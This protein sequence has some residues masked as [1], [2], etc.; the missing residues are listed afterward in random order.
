MLG[1]P[2]LLPLFIRYFNDMKNFWQ[3]WQKITK[4]IVSVQATVLL[5]IVYSI[6]IIPLG[7]FLK[8]FSKDILLGHRYSKKPHTFWIPVKKIKQDKA[9]AEGQ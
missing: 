8:L 3:K 9:F 1:I 5:T 7:F 6:L 2:E 4:K